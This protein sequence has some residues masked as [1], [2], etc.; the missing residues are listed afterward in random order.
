MPACR[1]GSEGDSED[2]TILTASPAAAFGTGL[3]PRPL[4]ET[5]ADIAAA[6]RAQS[7]GRPGIGLTAE[8]EAQLLARWAS[9]AS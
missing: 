5:V 6:E 1:C 9:A 3:S 4:R 2:A 8:R 7:G